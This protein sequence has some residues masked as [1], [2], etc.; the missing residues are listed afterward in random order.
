[1]SGQSQPLSAVGAITLF[2]DDPSRSKDWYER[3]FDRSAVYEDASSAVIR[4]GDML[5]NLL[6]RSAAD[7]LIAPAAVA[8]SGSA[9]AF[10]FT[11][12]VADVDVVATALKG[13]GVVL[14]NGPIDRAWGQRT[15]CFA[16]P[17]GHVWEIAQTIE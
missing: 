10:Q 16:D 17:D 12:W 1:M 7:E 3:V 9:A 5:V 14:V 4:F 11:I 13:R 2:V 8:A 6:A 15:I